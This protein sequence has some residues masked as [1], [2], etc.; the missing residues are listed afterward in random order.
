MTGFY[1]YHCSNKVY[2]TSKELE[3]LNIKKNSFTKRYVKLTN[4]PILYITSD[5]L[6]LSANSLKLL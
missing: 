6:N 1:I 2:V 3:L 4:F 5:Y